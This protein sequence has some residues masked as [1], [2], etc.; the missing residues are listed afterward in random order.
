MESSIK[1]LA[2]N[3]EPVGIENA[4]GQETK[5]KYHI[6]SQICTEKLFSKT[7]LC[8]VDPHSFFADPDPAVLLYA[9]PD[10]A[11]SEMKI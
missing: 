1:K 10:P 5:L 3:G 9:D 7:G 2:L 4:L 11:A 6:W 8:N